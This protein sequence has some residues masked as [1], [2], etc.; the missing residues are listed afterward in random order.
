MYRRNQFGSPE[1]NKDF[2]AWTSSMNRTS[3]WTTFYGCLDASVESDIK[4]TLNKYFG[5]SSRA[6]DSRSVFKCAYFCTTKTVFFTYFKQVCKCIHKSELKSSIVKS[7]VCVTAN[8]KNKDN[9]DQVYSTSQSA[10][11]IFKFETK[12]RTK[13]IQKDNK[14]SRKHHCLAIKEGI[15]TTADCSLKMTAVCAR[16]HSRFGSWSF[17]INSCLLKN[18]SISNNKSDFKDV[19]IGYFMYEED[20]ANQMCLA[21][22]RNDFTQSLTYQTRNCSD[23]LAVLCI[24]ENNL[25]PLSTSTALNNCSLPTTLDTGS[26]FSSNFK[27]TSTNI[28]RGEKNH[29]LGEIVIVNLVLFCLIIL[30]VTMIILRKRINLQVCQSAFQKCRSNNIKTTTMIETHEN[31]ASINGVPQNESKKVRGSYTEPLD[32]HHDI[33]HIEAVCKQDIMNVQ[34]DETEA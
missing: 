16:G 5:N 34:T 22:L 3:D 24:D 10:F 9:F 21:I 14:E 13:F 17:I 26:L 19:W 1:L 15:F 6:I 8:S 18:E 4:T 20:E 30:F 2:T 31:C 29:T 27:N 32:L 33:V 12:F 11:P 28:G 25:S 23:R 7:P